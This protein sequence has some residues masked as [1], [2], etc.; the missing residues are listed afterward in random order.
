LLRGYVQLSQFASQFVGLGLGLP[1]L[2]LQ[3][4]SGCWPRGLRF[5][6]AGDK[7]ADALIRNDDSRPGAG[8]AQILSGSSRRITAHVSAL[9]QSGG[10][11]G[12]AGNA[13]VVP[14]SAPPATYTAAVE[15]YLTGAGIAKSSA[16]I[17]RISLTT[18]GW[19]FAGERAPTGPARR[20]AKPP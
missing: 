10:S 9:A 17:Y 20:G 15:R 19:M 4:G 5:R 11:V 7:P 6:L 1:Q 8:V 13:R 3:A 18:W 16:R 2:P 12:S 14:M